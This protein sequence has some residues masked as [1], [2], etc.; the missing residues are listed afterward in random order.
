MDVGKLA[1]GVV[2]AILFLFFLLAFVRRASRTQGVKY[3][4][5]GVLLSFSTI[6]LAIYLVFFRQL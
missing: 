6:G 3:N 5:L 4:W 1:W 2:L